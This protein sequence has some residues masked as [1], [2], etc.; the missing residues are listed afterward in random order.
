[1]RLAKDSE[2]RENF[3]GNQSRSRRGRS[4]GFIVKGLLWIIFLGLIVGGVGTYYVYQQ[5][6]TNPITATTEVDIPA[7]SSVKQIA[8]LLEKNGVIKNATLFSY[9]VRYQGVAGDLKAGIYQFD[10][11]VTIEQLINMLSKG[12]QAEVV[13]FT[14]PEGWNVSQIA[15][16]LAKKGLIEK[17]IFIHEINEGNFPEFPFVSSIPKKE[18][19]K[20]RLEGYLFPE[21]YEVREGATEHEIIAKMLGQF[22]K[23]WKP[24]WTEQIKKHKI[25]M[26]EAVNLAAIVEREVVVDQERPIVA[27]IFYNRMRDRWKL[28]SCA[29]VQFVL[30]KQRDRITFEDL[31]IASPYNTYLHEGLPPGPIA[32]PGRASLESVVKPQENEYFFFVTKKDGTQE[33][34]FSKTFAEHASKNAKS[35]GSW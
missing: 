1:M 15:E 17:D 23:E 18:E 16:A 7:G 28:Q 34:Y 5:L 11:Q 8:T 6:Q 3:P 32:S 20:Y 13:R 2:E 24:E 9:Y 12:T 26:D 31:K 22:Q 30:G 4:G 19:R 25:T 21:T 29:T 27:G 35:Q 33:H 14:V 10:Q